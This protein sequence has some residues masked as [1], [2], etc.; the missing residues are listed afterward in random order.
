MKPMNNEIF[1][2]QPDSLQDIEQR[3]FKSICLE[4]W[5]SIKPIDDEIYTSVF[6]SFI[7]PKVIHEK[8]FE[9]VD[10]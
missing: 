9:S 3:I 10:T 4:V 6:F 1:G 8:L 5:S 2:P 7:V